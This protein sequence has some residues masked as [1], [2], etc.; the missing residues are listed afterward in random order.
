MSDFADLNGTRVVSGSVS[1]PSYGIWTANISLA[2][3]PTIPTTQGAITLTV[4]DLKLLGTVY[5]SGVYGGV[6]SV[7]LRG[8]YGGWGKTLTAKSYHF[9][10]GV[11]IAMILT[12]AAIEL[13]EQVAPPPPPG[14]TGP[15]FGR[16]AT[17]GGLL[18]GQLGPPHWYMAPNGQTTIGARPSTAIAS[19][20]Q[21][22]AYDPSAGHVTVASDSV[23]DFAPGRTFSAPQLPAPSPISYVEHVLDGSTVRT[24]ILLV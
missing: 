22:L 18:L 13:G 20:F 21:V 2:S 4:G 17:P 15:F 9:A 19:K 7:R 23:A 11:P 16:A 24:E 6:Y 12:D 5:R 14:V 3:A 8:G 1:I 10:S